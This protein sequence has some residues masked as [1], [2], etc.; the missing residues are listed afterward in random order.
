MM[1]WLPLLYVNP[2]QVTFIAVDAA[3]ALVVCGLLFPMRWIEIDLW[4]PLVHVDTVSSETD[5]G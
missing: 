2:I 1:M 3:V 4:L 5:S